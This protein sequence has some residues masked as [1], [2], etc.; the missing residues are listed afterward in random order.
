[1][2]YDCRLRLWPPGALAHDVKDVL[3]FYIPL[4]LLIGLAVALV[5]IAVRRLQRNPIVVGLSVLGLTYVPYLLSRTDEFHTTPLI[6]VLAGLLAILALRVPMRGAAILAVVL[7]ALV[8]YGASNRLSALFGP[9]RLA[10][11]DIAVADG[12]K[13]PPAEARSVELMV[14]TVQRRV[15]PGD[16]IYTVTRR[17]DLVRI[18]N[19]LIY[20]LTERDNPTRA[21]FGLQTGPVAQRSIVAALERARPKVIVRWLSPEST[22]REPNARG[23]PSGVQ[24]LDKWLVTS[25]RPAVRYGDYQLLV[26]R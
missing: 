5:A 7:L 3:A 23:R 22:K 13:A 20:V 15:P 17:S 14:K 10:T 21:D 26:P 8:A 12:V 25:Y 18:N 1:L 2:D 9:P 24:I 19:P 6:V 11:I 4:L 16:P